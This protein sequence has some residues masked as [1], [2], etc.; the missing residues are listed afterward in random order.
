MRES[1]K[2]LLISILCL[3]F[4]PILF[5]QKESDKLRNEQKQLQKRIEET[6]KLLNDA[7]NNQRLTMAELGIINQ[8]IAY[9][10]ELIGSFQQQVRDLNS[11]IEENRG[12]IQSLRDDHNRLISQYRNMI[13]AAYRNKSRS[14]NLMFVFSSDSFNQAYMRLKYTQ[15]IVEYRKR[16]IHLIEY[17]QAELLEHEEKLNKLLAEKQSLIG[18]TNKE[19]EQYDRDRQNQQKIL[20]ELQKNEGKLKKDLQ[21]Q[22]EKK[23]Q[24]DMAIKKAIQKEIEEEQRRQAAEAAKTG[25]KEP[26]LTP[27]AQLAAKNFEANK[28]RLPW[29]VERGEV[30]LGFGQVAHPVVKGVIINSNGI[31][32]TTPLGA[33]VRAIF[34]GE[35]AS[36]MVIPGAGKAVMISHGSYRTV[37]ANL[38]ETYV[39]KGDKVGTKQSIGV[40]LPSEE[41]NNSVCHLEIWKITGTKSAPQNPMGWI[42]R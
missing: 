35:V 22:E 20:A 17:T 4:A 29:P 2:K 31:D 11:R 10:A 3:F 34:E 36:V 37:Y 25:K 23:Q 14:G 5:G 7:R 30:T 24:L 13:L 38:K 42:Y 18:N 12:M 41:G 9:R 6:R 8:Q 28:G 33:G 40:L 39:Q 16:Q 19:R 32:I 21:Q 15:K 1:T 27:E 26:G